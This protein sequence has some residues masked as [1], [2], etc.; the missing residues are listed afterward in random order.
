M[1]EKAVSLWGSLDGGDDVLSA[2]RNGRPFSR[3]EWLREVRVANR[4]WVVATVPNFGDLGLEHSVYKA[5][6]NGERPLFSMRGFDGG[7]WSA[8]ENGRIIRFEKE[9]YQEQN[10]D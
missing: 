2:I 8:D 6:E 1:Y 4:T 3:P 7:E 9:R 5:L 10:K